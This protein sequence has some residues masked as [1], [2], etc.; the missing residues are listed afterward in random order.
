MKDSR[1]QV[2]RTLIKSFVPPILANITRPVRHKFSQDKVKFS[3]TLFAGDDFEYKQNVQSAQVIGEYGIGSSTVWAINNS[4]AEIVAV[5]DSAEWASKVQKYVDFSTRLHLNLIDRGPL[6]PWGRPESYSKRNE[7][8]RY[9][10]GIWGQPLIPDVVLV[11]G[12]FRVACFLASILSVTKTTKI[13]FDD[14]VDRDYYHVVE[15]IIPPI[16]FCGRQAIFEVGQ[17]VSRQKAE[18]LLISFIH[19]MD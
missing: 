8:E 5:E 6:G 2:L 16:G 15:E 7:F 4:Q 1:I 11:D 12:R 14:Y 9:I 10:F 3:T 13:F 17:L 18:E 19:V